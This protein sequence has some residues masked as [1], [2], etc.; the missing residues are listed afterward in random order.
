[1]LLPVYQSCGAVNRFA[2]AQVFL[3]MPSDCPVEPSGSKRNVPASAT[4]RNSVSMYISDDEAL[5]FSQV[6]DRQPLYSCSILHVSG[7]GSRASSLG[8]VGVK[9]V[10]QSG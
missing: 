3:A 5:S 2:L 10:A 6:S 4:G 9:F 1:M 8:E 7:G